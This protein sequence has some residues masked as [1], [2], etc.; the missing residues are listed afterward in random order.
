[1]VNAQVASIGSQIWTI[2]NLNV[3]TFRN[4]DEITEAKSNEQW[5]L[6]GKTGQPAWC[7]YDNNSNNGERYGKLYNWFAI[8]DPRG[9]APLG[10]RTPNDSDW[11]ILINFFGGKEV[12]GAK[13]KCSASDSELGTRN[14]GS[15]FGAVPSGFRTHDGQFSF[16]DEGGF[17]WS[18]KGY[19]TFNMLNNQIEYVFG[20]QLGNNDKSQSDWFTADGKGCGFSLRCIQAG[21]SFSINSKK[22][23]ITADSNIV[24]DSELISLRGPEG[25]DATSLLK[26][27]RGRLWLGTGSSGGVYSFDSQ[28]NEWVEFNKGIGPVH[29]IDIVEIDTKVILKIVDINKSYRLLN[30]YQGYSNDESFAKEFGITTRYYFLE[31]NKWMQLDTNYVGLVKS[32][33]ENKKLNNQKKLLEFEL[34][35][36]NIVGGLK[37]NLEYLNSIDVIDGKLYILDKR[38]LFYYDIFQNKIK[39]YTTKGL[40]ATDVYQ[41]LPD[42]NNTIYVWTNC[43]Q[44]YEYSNSRWS[45]RV[46]FPYH[47]GMVE[48]KSTYYG[49]ESY[50]EEPKSEFHKFL[51]KY[52]YT[53]YYLNG[54]DHGLKYILN[55]NQSFENIITNHYIIKNGYLTNNT[56]KISISLRGNLYLYNK[57]NNLIQN[58][59]NF[60]TMSG[61][62]YFVAEAM[63][64]KDGSVVAGVVSEDNRFYYPIRIK[65]NTIIPFSEIQYKIL[66]ALQQNG[67]SEVFCNGKPLTINSTGKSEIYFGQLS[68][69]TY[70]INRKEFSEI[71]LANNRLKAIVN[72]LDGYCDKQEVYRFFNLIPN[73]SINNRILSFYDDHYGQVFLGTGGS[74]LLLYRYK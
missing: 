52:I 1:M 61:I 64:D 28:K 63:V 59:E 36:R 51:L 58:I 71:N 44:L 74:G 22:K 48:N 16:I 69:K 41:I 13:M 62:N 42:N 33:I 3:D 5:E 38:G 57:K 26:D 17:F 12:A 49:K 10:W 46:D 29:V 2:V 9:L 7:Y 24:F 45:L 34:K 37:L 56:E 25:C 53:Q 68:A 65:N 4:G 40:F 47:F 32:E 14:S 27:S 73:N 55:D 50:R 23:S 72:M 66:P 18:S 35:N 60:K 70:T 20:N 15:F 8:N 30:D 39:K 31:D 43:L 19:Y 67:E 54:F 6:A 21:D 11:N